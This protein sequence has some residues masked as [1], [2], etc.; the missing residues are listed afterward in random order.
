ML[1]ECS[2]RGVLVAPKA[3]LGRKE[4]ARKPLSRP[5][6]AL[7]VTLQQTQSL[8]DIKAFQNYDYNDD[9]PPD[10]PFRPTIAKMC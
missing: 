2:A 10:E 4:P 3:R 1:C 9:Y 8:C 5:A 6:C 7:E